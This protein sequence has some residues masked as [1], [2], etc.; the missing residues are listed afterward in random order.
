[1]MVLEFCSLYRPIP[2]GNQTYKQLAGR[3]PNNMEVY[4]SLP[5]FSIVLSQFTIFFHSFI[6]VSQQFHQFH[7][8]K[9]LQKN[10]APMHRRRPWDDRTGTTLR[11][12]R[13]DDLRPRGP[14]QLLGESGF[15][16]CKFNLNIYIYDNNKNNHYYH[17]YHCHYHYHYQNHYHY[18]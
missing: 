11:R 8:S 7:Q 2:S 17:H 10:E 4:H 6:I 5:Y 14:R 9:P 3:S 13:L 15:M 18:I 16:L 1:M 12:Q